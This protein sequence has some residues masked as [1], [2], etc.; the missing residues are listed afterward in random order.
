MLFVLSSRSLQITPSRKPLR[1]A[2]AEEPRIAEVA[3]DDAIPVGEHDA[4]L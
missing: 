4:V 3:Y 1:R 2:V